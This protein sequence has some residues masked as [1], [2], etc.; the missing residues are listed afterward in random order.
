[1][2]FKKLRKKIK[3]E[4]QSMAIKFYG[5]EDITDL[6]V[7]ARIDQKA[8]DD[9]QKEFEIKRLENKYRREKDYLEQVKN[10]EIEMLNKELDDMKKRE[11]EVDKK[12]YQAKVQVN[13]NITVA[14]TLYNH[15]KNMTEYFGKEMAEIN[16]VYTSVKDHDKE[17]KKLE[18]K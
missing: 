7:Q 17:I 2:I 18:V 3:V 5:L 12:E 8:N 1:M 6:L 10:S 4:F 11:K 13:S 15:A 14:A 9:K 16:R